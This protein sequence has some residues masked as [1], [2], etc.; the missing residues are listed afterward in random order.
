[1][2]RKKPLQ[3]GISWQDVEDWIADLE[4]EYKVDADLII[5]T[6]ATPLT[7]S[8]GL[9]VTLRVTGAQQ[10]GRVGFTRDFKASWP[11]YG[12]KTMPGLILYLVHA[13]REGL[14]FLPPV[15]KPQRKSPAYPAG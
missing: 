1:M 5:S 10:S 8:M 13:A 12:S 15:Y 9:S 7:G 6:Q 14:H 4:K 3:T 2:T 11:C